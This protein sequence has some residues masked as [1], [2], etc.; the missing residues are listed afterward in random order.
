MTYDELWL[1]EFN[2]LKAFIEKNV[3]VSAVTS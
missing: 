3:S 1:Q 2:E